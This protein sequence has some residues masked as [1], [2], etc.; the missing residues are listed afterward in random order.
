MAR[1]ISK[2]VNLLKPKRRW[3][4]FSLATMFVVVTVLC[5]WLSVLADRA[6]RQQ[7]AVAAIEAMGGQ[8]K[9]NVDDDEQT[10]AFP[11]SLLRRW[12]R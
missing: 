7:A 5:V 11:K 4:Q 9:Y 3:A 6:N 1:P 2:L 12:P 10:E 8:V